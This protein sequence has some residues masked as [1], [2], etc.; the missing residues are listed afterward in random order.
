MEQAFKAALPRES[1]DDYQLANPTDMCAD[2]L[3]MYW[4]RE[5]AG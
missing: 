3:R 5:A 2:G 4:E 1:W